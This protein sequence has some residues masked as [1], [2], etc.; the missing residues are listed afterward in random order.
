MFCI[1][2]ETLTQSQDKAFKKL[3]EMKEVCY[4]FYSNDD[5]HVKIANLY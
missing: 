1:R 2:Q 3:A 5:R 4:Y